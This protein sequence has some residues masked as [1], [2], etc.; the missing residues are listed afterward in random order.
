MELIEALQLETVH[1]HPFQ[2][3]SLELSFENFQHRRVSNTGP[4][5]PEADMLLPEQ[6]RRTF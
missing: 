1:L 5:E 6:A 4:I 3:Q 2:P